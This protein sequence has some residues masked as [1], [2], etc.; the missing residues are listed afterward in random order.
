MTFLH[1]YAEENLGCTPAYECDDI[2]LLPSNRSKAVRCFQ[3]VSLKTLLKEFVN[4][5]N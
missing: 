3:S 4:G 2:K 5:T 1:N